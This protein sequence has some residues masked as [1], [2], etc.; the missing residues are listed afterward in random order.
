[1]AFAIIGL[2]ATIAGCSGNKEQTS[3]DTTD[4]TAVE[5][6]YH[7]DHDIAMVVRSVA[8]AIRVGEPLDSINYDYSGILT[9]GRGYPLY[10]DTRGI[11]G[12]WQVDVLSPTAVKICNKSIGDLLPVDLTNYLTGVLNL[13]DTDII[14]TE[15]SDS[16]RV[17]YGFK[18]GYL[19]IETETAVNNGHEGSLMTIT[20][21]KTL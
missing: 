1:M 18:G 3:A 21:S 19:Q 11:P 13:S 5:E 9:D 15:S 12:E 16:G 20:A 14:P 10:T 7:A 17:V 2:S 4:T 6:Y 8:D